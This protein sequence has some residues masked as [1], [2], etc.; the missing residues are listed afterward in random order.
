M[1]L[2]QELGIAGGTVD[3]DAVEK[4]MEAGGLCPEGIHHAV[5][6]AAGVKQIDGV[7]RGYELTFRVLAGPGAGSEV[8]EIVWLPKGEDAKKDQTATDRLL[9]FAIKLGVL[10]AERK[11]G[12]TV[13][14]EIPGRSDFCDVLGA[15]CFIDVHHE[16]REFDGKSGR[17]KIKEAK[18]TFRPG[19]LTMNDPTCAKIPRGKPG[20]VGQSGAAN[21]KPK[22]NFDTLINV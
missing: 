22:D 20:P 18:L 2:M 16:E 4:R 10:K 8:K 6:D 11:D 15:E 12:K 1:G 9:T 14:V 3:V 5:L 17:K 21:A 7:K 13:G 19:V